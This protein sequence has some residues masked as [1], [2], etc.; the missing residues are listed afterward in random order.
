M[1]DAGGA[2]LRFFEKYEISRNPRDLRGGWGLLFKVTAASYSLF[3][4]LTAVSVV[5]SNVIRGLFLLFISAMVFLKYPRGETSPRHRPS[6]ADLVLVALAAGAFGNFVLDYDEMAWRAG[7]PSVRDV[8]WGLVTIVLVL[9]TA[10]RAMSLILPLIA[11]GALLYGF[12]GPLFPGVFAHQGFT[13]STIVGDTYA[14][15]NGI[16]GIVAYVFSAYVVIFIVLAA[17]LDKSGAGGFFIDW[18]VALS[19]WLRGGP[20]KAVVFTSTLFG[21]ISGSATANTVAT[22]T[23]TIP[24]MKKAGYRPEVAG[25][26]EPAVDVGGMFMPPVMG[27]GAFLMA[28]MMRIPYLEVVKVAIV[29]ALI[30]FFSTLVMVHF[31]AL[32]TGIGIVPKEQRIAAAPIF[33]RNWYWGL[34]VVVLFYLILDGR[35]PSLSGVAAIATAATICL[36][37]NV[38]QGTPG[39]TFT[40]IFDGLATGGTQSLV[41]GA[42]AGPVGIIVGMALLTGLAFNFSALVLSYTHGLPWAALLLVMVATFVLGMGMTVTADYLILAIMAVP[43]MVQIGIPPL[44]A[45]FAVFWYSQ[46]SNVTPPVCMSVFAGAGIAG[47]H[48]YTTAVHA[49]RF[50]AYLYIMPFM[51]V[52]TPI[53]M[54][55]GFSFGVLVSWVSGFL[56]CVPFAAAMTGYLFGRLGIGARVLLFAS[57]LLLLDPHWF[58]SL[59]GLAILLGVASVQRWQERRLVAATGAASPASR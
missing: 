29:P 48:P 5:P 33:W 21:M 43:A 30:Y 6:A 58:T 26:I 47:T 38:I 34:P 53:L 37:K 55:G 42:T 19:S 40:Q 9:E 10:R 45:H 28:E 49:M 36:A 24:M 56:S 3:L 51:F 2:I 27:A 50:S 46:S 18:P 39:R 12:G 32:K 13:A 54:P 59:I 17:F 23:F 7:A 20:A 11:V 44:A 16:F 8:A 25:A 1:M 31:E 14:S 4:I 52:Y 57:T 22:G 35:S 15:L 41:I